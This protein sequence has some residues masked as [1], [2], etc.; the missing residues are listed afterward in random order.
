MVPRVRRAEDGEQITESV[1]QRGRGGGKV[2]L[3][4]VDNNAGGRVDFAR[5]LIR[6]LD[7]L[8]KHVGHMQWFIKML[9]RKSVV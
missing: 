7:S 2:T 1:R 8:R 9:D 4:R 3:F 6:D 5:F